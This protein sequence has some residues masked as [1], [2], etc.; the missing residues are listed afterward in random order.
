MPTF[1]D[2]LM[3]E[4]DEFDR[5][6][7]SER[8]FDD[9]LIEEETTPWQT[10]V[11]G[12]ER[13]GELT[14]TSSPYDPLSL[15]NWGR[16]WTTIARLLPGQED[17]AEWE[18]QDWKRQIL[19]G[20]QIGV[21]APL[22][23]TLIQTGVASL[24]DIRNA[25]KYNKV[26]KK[27]VTKAIRE[28][29]P[30]FTEP[31][32]YQVYTAEP[33]YPGH[34]ATGIRRVPAQKVTGEEVVLPLVKG[35]PTTPPSMTV[36]AKQFERGG[37]A[38]VI[39][40]VKAPFAVVETVKR[41][42]LRVAI[43]RLAKTQ[44]RATVP[45]STVI[46]K[47]A[48]DIGKHIVA[49]L[50]TT[51]KPQVAETM[52]DQALKLIAAAIPQLKA[53]NSFTIPKREV[54][55][56][57]T[58]LMKR[59]FAERPLA[60]AEV[61]LPPIR[62]RAVGAVKLPEKKVEVPP[63]KPGVKEE[64]ISPITD[65]QMQ[66]IQSLQGEKKFSP[67]LMRKAT[68]AFADKPTV[69]ALDEREAAALIEGMKAV[70]LRATG[71]PYI[72]AHRGDLLP[73]DFFTK[74]RAAGLESW[75][76]P[77]WRYLE[78]LGAKEEIYDPVEIAYIA[79]QREAHDK[80]RLFTELKKS[81]KGVKGSQQR[82]FHYLN[83]TLP[84]RV[85]LSPEET[86]AA[87]ELRTILDDYADRLGLPPE[88]RV[89]NYIYHLFEASTQREL[90]EKYP[91]VDEAHKDVPLTDAMISALGLKVPEEIFT[92]TLLHRLGKKQGLVEDVWKAM[93]AVTS[94]DLRRI[95]MQPALEKV[96]P[97]V[98]AY[99][100]TSRAYI[101]DWLSYAV[102]KQQPPL[103][104][105]INASTHNFTSFMERATKGKISF[106]SNPMKT[107]GYVFTRVGYRVARAFNIVFGGKNVRQQLLIP[108]LL[109]N[110]IHYGQAV[111]DLFTA[112]GQYLLKQSQVL[113]ERFP[114]EAF[115][116][117]DV[118]KWL[119]KGMEPYKL[120][121]W[122]NVSTAFLAGARDAVAMN[123]PP[124]EVIKYADRIAKISQYSYRPIDMSRFMWQGGGVGRMAGM[125]QTWP[126]N[127]FTN[128]LPELVHGTV[129]GYDTAGNKLPAYARGRLLEHL[130]I[131]SL[132]IY[133]MYKFARVDFRKT[134]GPGVMPT[135]LAPTL[136]LTLALGQNAYGLMTNDYEL[137]KDAQRKLS[138]SVPIFIPAGLQ[139]KKTLDA[140]KKLTE[141][142]ETDWA[143]KWRRNVSVDEAIKGVFTYPAERSDFWD[144]QNKVWELDGRMR[145]MNNQL[146]RLHN[147]GANYNRVQRLQDKLKGLGK[148]RRRFA[149]KLELIKQ[150]YPTEDDRE[151]IEKLLHTWSLW[152]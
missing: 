143:G 28:I 44:L 146:L 51:F 82:L 139:T 33:K 7:L 141:G 111:G 129:T 38:E 75:G 93:R 19:T 31:G 110:P 84:E 36:L 9:T 88:R 18:E 133:G 2:L 48:V 39:K 61:A 25:F 113:T 124:D 70:P 140:Y 71:K 136:S 15:A 5:M 98:S 29:K 87:T 142:V 120:V 99:P 16:S 60:E 127:Y 94:I 104:K 3:N 123:L 125:L 67:R 69:E 112:K 116:P 152:P 73:S 138:N 118:S 21:I 77:A 35:R 79:Y 56:P 72:P 10:L 131:A 106:G 57:V 134:F 117:K 108:P 101:N 115:D 90:R 59:E 114:M 135:Y 91:F 107:T 103:D 54:E 83:G 132:F 34:P 45:T 4:E 41:D 126:I 150:G 43:E 37:M 121:D 32:Q 130:I 55:A 22:L 68:M 49:G 50:P 85:T 12:I 97:L 128:Y 145:N 147:L 137:Q 66:T 151:W 6:L 17:L 14:R 86:V 42:P 52:I 30:K 65:H 81:V 149:E 105:I 24:A 53:F 8:S 100:E 80:Y 47:T 102:L 144:T 58:E 92:P 27:T 122:L 26:L 13:A 89:E 46:E 109:H 76:V 1:D 11:G 20:A 74:G 62:E 148:Q 64:I 96:R 95:H 23:Y 40:Q 63:M 78:I 119:Q